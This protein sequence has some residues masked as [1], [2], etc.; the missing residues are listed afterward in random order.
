MIRLDTRLMLKEVNE[1]LLLKG[2]PR[3]MNAFTE[4]QNAAEH[5]FLE[6]ENPDYELM[7]ASDAEI[8]FEIDAIG[9]NIEKVY[10][11]LGYDSAYYDK[12]QFGVAS[13]Y[14]I[15]GLHRNDEIQE[16]VLNI[17]WRGLSG[18]CNVLEE[19]D[20]FKILH[21]EDQPQ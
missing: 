8:Q 3:L 17:F 14:G 18:L 11:F 21:P 13:I 4:L 1:E 7:Y 6:F 19:L 20:A 12:F 2:K 9:K 15:N 5:V 16:F 10:N